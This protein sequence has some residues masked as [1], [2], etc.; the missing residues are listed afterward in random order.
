MKSF[1]TVAVGTV[2]GLSTFASATK[3]NV[4]DRSSARRADCHQEPD[5]RETRFSGRPKSEKHGRMTYEVETKQNGKSRDLAFAENGSMLETEQAVDL[6]GIPVRAK[7][8]IQSRAA[9]GTIMKVES[10]TQWSSTSYE[11]NV[12]RGLARGRPAWPR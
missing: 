5:Q 9:G 4:K 3:V 2:F 6:N 12:K 8:A 10:V 1:V 7:E 11:A